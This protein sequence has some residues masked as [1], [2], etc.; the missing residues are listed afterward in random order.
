MIELFDLAPLVDEGKFY[1]HWAVIALAL[2]PPLYALIVFPNRSEIE[3]K[4]YETNRF[5]S[6]LIRFIAVPFIYI[7]FLILYAYS[8]KVLMNFSDWPKGMISWMVIAF[9]TFGYVAYIFSEPYAK[10]GAHIALFRKYFPYAV[11]PQI[12]MLFYAI[13]LRIA[14][15]DLT[16]NRYFVVIFGI[17]LLG[18]SLYLII[19]QRKSLA[20]ITAS[21]TC[22]SLLISV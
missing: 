6:F 1:S 13:Y 2:I 22:I 19:S 11:V 7:Y 12:F 14:Q 17:W 3:K 8:A 15:Y 10:N 16:M 4:T 21:L 20:V 5:F 18:I 9:S